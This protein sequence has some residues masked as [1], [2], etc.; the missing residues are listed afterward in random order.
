MRITFAYA[1]L[2]E[3]AREFWE[4]FGAGQ[5]FAFNGDMGA[6]KTTFIKALCAAKGVEDGTASPTFSIINEYRYKDRNGRESVIF[7][8]DL[9]R[10]KSLEEAVEAGVEDCFYQ[11]GAICFVE[12]PDLVTPLL[13]PD[14]VHVYLSV[15]PGQQR[16]LVAG[17]TGP[18]DFTPSLQ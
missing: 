12:W 8:L 11:P 15:T 7:H 14:T 16:R 5:V 6:G 4:T 17:T 18:A 10:L 3:V 1:D 2:P 13:P 9:Y